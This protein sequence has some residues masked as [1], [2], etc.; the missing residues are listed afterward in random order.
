MWQHQYCSAAR[1]RSRPATFNSSSWRWKLDWT[2]GRTF[3]QG[4][5]L[6]FGALQ[7]SCE[8]GEDSILDL[9]DYCHRKLTLLASKATREGATTQDQQQREEKTPPSAVEV[10]LHHF[11][12]GETRDSWLTLI[13]HHSIFI[14]EGAGDAKSHA[15]VWNL[16]E[17]R[18]SAAL[19][20]GSHREVERWLSTLLVIVAPVICHIL[21]LPTASQALCCLFMKSAE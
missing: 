6:R 20:H 14:G 10:W 18:V 1:R 19:H 12:V 7:D 8:A 9:V 17:G 3:C 5:V 15:G 2:V 16:P 4:D 13:N 21:S 11:A